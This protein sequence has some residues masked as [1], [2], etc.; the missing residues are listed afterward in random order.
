MLSKKLLILFLVV[1]FTVLQ[2]TLLHYIRIFESKPDILLIL[3]IFF[4]LHHGQIYGLAVGALCALFSEATC[5]LPTGA[6]VFTYSLAGLLLG[7][8]ARWV[9]TRRVLGQ[10]SI[11]FIFCCLIYLF[12]FLVFQTFGANS[13]RYSLS[14]GTG[15]SLGNALISII[16]PASF[17]TAC[18]SPLVFWF[19]KTIYPFSLPYKV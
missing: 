13:V 4:S 15:L 6:A 12:L 10:M 9:Y 1:L 5:G 2:C 8:I 17:Y 19:L 7:H 18:V 16:L 11:S 14:N 3:I